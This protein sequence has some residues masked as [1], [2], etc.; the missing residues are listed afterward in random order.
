MNYENQLVTPVSDAEVPKKSFRQL[1]LEAK[2]DKE[3]ERE[4]RAAEHLNSESVIRFDL[5]GAQS[6]LIMQKFVL[7]K[8]LFLSLEFIPVL[9]YKV[10]IPV[11][12]C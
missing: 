8:G 2:R 9:H 4:L 12:N 6:E 1:A 7:L 11:N 10:Q 3:R 5:D